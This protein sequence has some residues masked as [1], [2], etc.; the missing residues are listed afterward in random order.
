MCVSVFILRRA[1]EG[2]R[3]LMTDLCRVDIMCFDVSCQSLTMKC[4]RLGLIEGLTPL[5]LLK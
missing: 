3:C 1:G 5:L 4:T 2:G